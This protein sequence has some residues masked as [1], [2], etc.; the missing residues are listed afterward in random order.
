MTEAII[1]KAFL[2][3]HLN[4]YESSVFSLDLYFLSRSNV[5]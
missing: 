4:A 3:S 2:K 5:R 1:A